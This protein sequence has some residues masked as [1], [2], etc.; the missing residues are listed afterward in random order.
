MPDSGEKVAGAHKKFMDALPE[1]TR[2]FVLASDLFRGSREFLLAW[3]LLEA[4]SKFARSQNGY[5]PPVFQSGAACLG[6]ALELGLK[7]RIV[8]DGGTP[9]R[10]GMKAHSYVR[11]FEEHLSAGAQHDVA[12]L[13][14]RNPD[15]RQASPA[16]LVD[17]LRQF[18]GTFVKFRYVH[19][20]LYE[21]GQAV[22]HQGDLLNVTHAVHDSI[23]RLRPDFRPWAGV[24]WERDQD[25]RPAAAILDAMTAAYRRALGVE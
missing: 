8:I 3:Q 24:I 15:L 12:A 10:R 5:A 6:L 21:E 2:R 22:F 19:E 13:V 17:V 20:T 9:P 23:L 14:R 25:T 7:A 11:L 1:D 18:D 4:Y 16:E